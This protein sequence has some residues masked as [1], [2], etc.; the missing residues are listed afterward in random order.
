M[1]EP[2]RVPVCKVILL[3]QKVKRNRSTKQTDLIGIV[4]GGFAFDELPGEVGPFW[5]YV[6]LVQG[7][8]KFAIRVEIQDLLTGESLTDL[9]T[10]EL[11]FSEPDTFGV[12]SVPFRRVRFTHEGAYDFVVF[13]DT[14]EI[15]RLK[16]RVQI[17]RN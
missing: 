13:A 1:P 2:R 12:V 10:R 15:A 7:V 8:G 14:D 17:V 9:P 3:C 5:G 16:F 6:R 11:E 4:E